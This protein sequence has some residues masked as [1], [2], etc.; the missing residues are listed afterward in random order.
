MTAA[1][2]AKKIAADH[3]LTR[4]S[5]GPATTSSTAPSLAVA[6]DWTIAVTDRVSDFDEYETRFTVPIK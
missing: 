2:P 1:M 3:A 4:T 5:P 6:G